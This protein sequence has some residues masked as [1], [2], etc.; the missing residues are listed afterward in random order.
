MDARLWFRQFQ[1]DVDNPREPEKFET[2]YSLINGSPSGGNVSN[3]GPFRVPAR[4]AACASCPRGCRMRLASADSNE[5]V[6]AGSMFA[7]IGGGG[8]FGGP[9]EARPERNAPGTQPEADPAS[10]RSDA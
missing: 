1:W 5:S 4:A 8:M 6:C 2:G 3:G 7:N 9:G 10:Q